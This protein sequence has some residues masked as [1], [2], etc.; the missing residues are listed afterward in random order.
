MDEEYDNWPEDKAPMT[1]AIEAY[2]KLQ[3]DNDAIRLAANS[4]LGL[5]DCLGGGRDLDDAGPDRKQLAELVN[6][7]QALAALQGGE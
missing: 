1:E 5:I 6:Y 2:E 4:L 3:A 7:P